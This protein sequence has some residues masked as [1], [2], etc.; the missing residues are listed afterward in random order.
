M[1]IM[2]D[3]SDGKKFDESRKY[4][5]RILNNVKNMSENLDNAEKSISLLKKSL[6]EIDKLCQ[7]QKEA[8]IKIDDDYDYW[9]TG[10]EI[11]YGPEGNK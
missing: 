9:Y 1:E 10:D 2:S 7:E 11:F 5:N 4:L 8:L 6:T 3:C